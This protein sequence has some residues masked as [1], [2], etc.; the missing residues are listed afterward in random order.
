[1]VSIKYPLL[2]NS[3]RCLRLSTFFCPLKPCSQQLGTGVL[4]R[5]KFS[6]CEDMQHVSWNRDVIKG[7]A[8]LKITYHKGIIDRKLFSHFSPLILGS[9]FNCYV[10]VE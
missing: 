1:M 6:N 5:S 3:L 8:L 9:S 10:L 2:T 7:K 4:A